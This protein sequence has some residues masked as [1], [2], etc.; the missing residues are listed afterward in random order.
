V[1]ATRWLA[2]I[3]AAVGLLTTFA[4][5]AG[6]APARHAATGGTINVD[7]Q[8]DLDYSDPALDYF[9]PGWELEY[10]TCLKLLNY[11]DGN[12]PQSSQLVPEAAA[13]FPKVS[14]GGKTYDFTVNASWTK[15]SNGQPVT[16][17]SFKAAFDRDADPKMQSPAVSF[18]SDVVGADK[19]P[20]S[21]VVVK[22][23]HLIIHLTKPA[24]DFE[25]RVAM[26]FFCAVPANLARDPNG[27]L[28][29]PSAGPYYIASR[30]P[31][32][33]IVVKRNPNYHGKRPHNI[34]EI[35]YFV[36]QTLDASYLRVQQGSTDYA[37]SGIPPAA[38]AQAAQAS[39]VNAAKPGK[40]QLYVK[41]ILSVNYFS[42]NHDRP[43]FKLGAPS[44]D[45]ALGNV[46]LMKAINYAID[47]HAILAQ[48]GYL[49]GKRTDQILPPG[50][51]GFR[52]ANLYPLKGP[53]IAMAKKLAQGHTGSGTF[54]FYTCNAGSCP[55]RAQILQFDLKQI[56][57]NLDIRPFARAV[58]FT[59]EG[60]KGEPYDIGDDGWLA[61]YADPYD[62][63]NVLLDGTTI[64]DT[65]N[66]N[67]A[68]FND[69]K[70]NKLMA[71]AQQLSGDARYAAYG[72]LDVNIMMNAV[73]WAPRSNQN[74][75]L[76]VSSHMGNFTYNNVYGVDFAA[77]TRK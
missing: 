75:R 25:A 44:S 70:Y 59:K 51:A 72:A 74:N 14:A 36:G 42:F 38:Y 53:N 37:A 17:A 29:P 47:R 49:A 11:K 68:Y 52:D 13:G 15:F 18:F 16:A 69:P 4:A 22:G 46:N 62:F 43:N 63:I 76:F 7:L 64:H 30:T 48:S 23:S 40:T 66:N 50:M 65:N 8:S 33:E 27:V 31:N 54:V 56:G 9:Q 58:Q 24:P 26:P 55:L 39:G 35:H 2:A 32:K 21:G 5:A 60:D 6:A 10:S 20:V 45:P 34:S 73:P 67:L 71:Q 12:G 19:S 3:A 61:D 41:P 57:I 77:I 1:S 28:A